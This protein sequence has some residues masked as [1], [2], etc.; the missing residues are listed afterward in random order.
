MCCVG[1]TRSAP[2]RFAPPSRFHS[3]MHRH[4]AVPKRIPSHRLHLSQ[5]PYATYDYRDTDNQCP[6]RSASRQPPAVSFVHML[7][8]PHSS[9]W[10]SVSLYRWQ[11]RTLLFLCT[12]CDRFPENSLDKSASIFYNLTLIECFHIYIYIFFFRGTFPRKNLEISVFS[13]S[14]ITF[15]ILIG[16]SRKTAHRL[17]TDLPRRLMCCTCIARL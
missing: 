14:L 10:L 6:P 16:S 12:G 3:V 8:A 17:C 7:S 1:T 15:E 5:A 11:F 9:Y 4:S 2:H 13:I